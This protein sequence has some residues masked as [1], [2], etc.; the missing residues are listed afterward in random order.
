MD[1][2]RPL[3]G[4]N[5]LAQP[6][7]QAVASAEFNSSRLPGFALQMSTTTNPAVSLI[8]SPYHTRLRLLSFPC[9]PG[10]LSRRLAGGSRI[11]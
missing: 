4:G 7:V 9:W 6:R 8:L 2:T 5:L 3:L 10:D 1:V 11:V